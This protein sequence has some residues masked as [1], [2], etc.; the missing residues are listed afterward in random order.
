MSDSSILGIEKV[1]AD[2]D[3]AALLL[4]PLMPGKHGGLTP[5]QIGHS[6][7]RKSP[8]C[9]NPHWKLSQPMHGLKRPSLVAHV[10]FRD[11][12]R[13]WVCKDDHNRL[14]EQGGMTMLKGKSIIELTDVHGQKEVYEDENLATEAVFDV[15]N[16]NLQGSDV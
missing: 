14:S 2:C 3:D 15:L 4:S 10:P 7:L 13:E 8:A 9:Q 12:R 5:A 11:Q 6:Y 16:T 1:I